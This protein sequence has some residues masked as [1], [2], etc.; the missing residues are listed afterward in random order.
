MEQVLRKITLKLDVSG[1]AQVINSTRLYKGSYRFVGLQAY[2]PVTQN[3]DVGLTS[4][5]TVAAVVTDSRGQ[6][7]QAGEKY[8]NLLYVETVR[9]DGYDYMLFERPLPKTFTDTTGNL[10]F[11]LNYSEIDSTGLLSSRMPTNLYKT[12]VDE[13]GETDGEIDIDLKNQEAAQINANT[14]AIEQLWEAV[15]ELRETYFVVDDGFPYT[16]D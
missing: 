5:C 16:K 6:R 13:G 1:T 15:D 7:Q 2:V 11:F 10:E 12:T 4:L 3:R 9:L 14:I 8:Y